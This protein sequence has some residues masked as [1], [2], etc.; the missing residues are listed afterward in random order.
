MDSFIGT[1]QITVTVTPQP[2]DN[3][4]IL[5]WVLKIATVFLGINALWLGFLSILDLG[6]CI[7]GGLIIGYLFLKNF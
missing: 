6:S 4:V 1:Q 7:F 2:Q 5:K 3:N